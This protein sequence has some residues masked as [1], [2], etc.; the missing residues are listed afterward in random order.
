RRVILAVAATAA[1]TCR[2]RTSHPER[3]DPDVCWADGN[4]REYPQSCCGNHWDYR[5]GWIAG[6]HEH[7]VHRSGPQRNTP[8]TKHRLLVVFGAAVSWRRHLPPGLGPTDRALG[9]TGTIL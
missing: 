6:H 1:Q 2:T 3:P 7:A 4:G 5:H 8:T 9:C